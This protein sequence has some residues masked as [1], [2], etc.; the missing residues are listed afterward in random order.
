[1]D[2]INVRT[3]LELQ[4][5]FVREREWARF[6]TPKNLSMA[7]A[8]ESSELM[9]IFQWLTQAESKAVMKTPARAQAVRDE[10]A[11]VFYYLLRLADVLGVDLERAYFEKMERNAAKYPVKHAKGNARKYHEFLETKGLHPRKRKAPPQ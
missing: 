9:E 11:D 8:G 3:M 4:R 10:M 1:M 7:L 6:H 2:V 5:R